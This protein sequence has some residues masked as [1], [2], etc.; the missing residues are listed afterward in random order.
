[1]TN[2]N[3]IIAV[4][5][6]AVQLY[7]VNITTFTTRTIFTVIT[8]VT[9]VTIA[10]ITVITVT[11]FTFRTY[12]RIWRYDQSTFILCY[13]QQCRS[14]SFEIQFFIFSSRLNFV[15]Q[16]AVLIQIVVF[17][18]LLYFSGEFFQT[19]F[20]Q[21]FCVRQFYFRNS[22]FYSTFNV[23]QQ[24]TF[25]V[26]NEQQRAVSTIRTIG[27]ID[28]VNV[29]FRIYRDIVVNY[30]VDTFNVQVT[31]CNVGRNQDVQTIIFQAFQ[32]LFTQRLVYVIVQR[33]VVVV[34]TFKSFSYFQSRVFGTNEDNRRIKIFR[35][36][37][38]YQ[39]FVFAYI[40]DS[41]VVLVDV[42]TGSYV[43]LNAYFLRFFYKAAGNATNRFRYGCREQSG[44]MIFR[45]LRYNGF[46]VF[47]EVYAQYF[48]SF[49]QNQIV[50]FREVQ[51][52]TFQV[53]QQTV[54]SIDN[55]L[56]FLTQ[57]A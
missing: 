30:Q 5:F 3:I 45:D 11:E 7:I 29:R 39:C 20:V 13:F 52:V 37:E 43:G 27:T 10:R 41:L 32:C 40:L 16:C 28:T 23:A 53:V 8:R 55:D 51:S 24:T 35:F 54:R 46:N 49:I 19:A 12:R 48:V 9:V 50:Q 34:V 22:Q 15:Q 26:F 18:L 36:Q 2:F 25:A 42:R 31:G 33:G 21:Q 6:N 47:D 4:Y 57:G 38:T 1:M 17:Q 44:L 56:R 14:Q